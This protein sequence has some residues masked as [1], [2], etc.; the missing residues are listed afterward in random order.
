MEKQLQIPDPLFDI[1]K[2]RWATAQCSKPD[3]R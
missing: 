2:G 3:F 1:R